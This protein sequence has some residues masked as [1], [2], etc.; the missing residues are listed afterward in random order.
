MLLLSADAVLLIVVYKGTLSKS[1][2]VIISP[3]NVLGEMQ[4]N[5]LN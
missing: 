5:A 1:T 4:I 2:A 3:N